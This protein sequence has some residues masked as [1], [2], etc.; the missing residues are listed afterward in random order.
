LAQDIRRLLTLAYPSEQSRV[1]EHI[2][3]DAFLTA[4]DDAELELKIR[5]RDSRDLDTAVRLAQRFEVLKRT[6]G[7]APAR[8]RA[9]RQVTKQSEYTWVPSEDKDFQP[10]P[11]LSAARSETRYSDQPSDKPQ[12]EFEKRRRNKAARDKKRVR[13][14]EKSPAK[15]SQYPV[16]SRDH[17]RPPQDMQAEKTKLATDLGK[18]TAERD[19][20]VERGAYLESQLK[21]AAPSPAQQPLKNDARYGG[22]FFNSSQGYGS[23]NASSGWVVSGTQGAPKQPNCCW[24][25]GQP[26]H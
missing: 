19:R 14:V 8:Y 6:V 12:H 13:A 11:R 16:T 15:S 10:V 26:G 1:V 22:N 25:C 2:G 5:D 23:P 3:R 7:A 17:Q 4:L 9:T 20:L 24:Q 21:S 18:A